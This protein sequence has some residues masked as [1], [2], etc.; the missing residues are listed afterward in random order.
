MA[1]SG[2]CARDIVPLVIETLRESGFSVAH[3]KIKVMRPGEKKIIN[4]LV[5]GKF[6]TVER[7]YLGR[8]RAGIHNLV[9]GKV[10]ASDFVRYVSSLEGQINYVKL[11]DSKKAA[12]LRSDLA[13]AK[14]KM[15]QA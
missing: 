2:D 5:L 15:A 3:R 6:V 10:R 14:G 4:N 8:I 1:F 12:R 11:F 13:E 9:L 7:A